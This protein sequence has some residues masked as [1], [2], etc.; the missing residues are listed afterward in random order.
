MENLE[1]LSWV[2][3]GLG[4][5]ASI[6]AW[7]KSIVKAKNSTKETKL[8]DNIYCWIVEAEKIFSSMP[9]SGTMKLNQVLSSALRFCVNN[10]MK[11]NEDKIKLEIER[12]VD[13]SNF[14]NTTA[15]QI[16]E[17]VVDENIINGFSNDSKDIQDN[18]Q[19]PYEPLKREG[20]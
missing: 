15:K 13:T 12:I 16:D 14:V 19:N 18:S 2:A 5:F 17:K 1:I 8:L 11:Y 7:I 10:K 9:K 4:I 20:E 3:T 6:I